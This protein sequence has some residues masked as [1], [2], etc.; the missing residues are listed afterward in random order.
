VECNYQSEILDQNIKDGLCE[1]GLKDRLL[2]THLSLNNVIEFLK[3][4][5]LSR[6]REVYLMHLSSRNANA[7]QM[8]DAIIKMFGK[9]VF[10][11]GMADHVLEFGNGGVKVD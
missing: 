5:D 1:P 2:R 10:V 8:K 9:P 11:C 7:K 4:N 3:A 6:T